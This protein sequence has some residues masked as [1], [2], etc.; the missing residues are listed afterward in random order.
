MVTKEQ[1]L[2][3]NIFH[4]CGKTQCSSVIGKR[5]AV[6][7]KQVVCRRNGKTQL[8]KRS[9]ERFRVPV[10][11]GLY[12]YGEITHDNAKDWHTEENCPL[13]VA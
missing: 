13:N 12:T 8:W 7:V 3:A 11:C 10:K 2:T 5:G 6:T 9:A 1:A 4:Y